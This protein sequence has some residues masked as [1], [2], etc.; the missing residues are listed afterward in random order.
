METD[1]PQAKVTGTLNYH[2]TAEGADGLLVQEKSQ[3]AEER[4]AELSK[5]LP[6][7]EESD[8]AT[9]LVVQS[10][11]GKENPMNF[12]QDNIVESVDDLANRSGDGSI[13][14]GH[15]DIESLLD[16]IHN[17]NPEAAEDKETY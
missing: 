3:N 15:L 12:Y 17:D 8:C 16:A 5:W 11:P 10:E 13:Q 9:V 1:G 6:A 2:D 4:A 14:T 7:Q